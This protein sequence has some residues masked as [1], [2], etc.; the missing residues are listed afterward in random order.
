MFREFLENEVKTQIMTFYL[1]SWPFTMFFSTS[2]AWTR[3]NLT[4][5]YDSIYNELLFLFF[6]IE[7]IDACNKSTSIWIEYIYRMRLWW[8]FEQKTNT[9]WSL[10]KMTKILFSEISLCLA[11]MWRIRIFASKFICLLSELASAVHNLQNVILKLEIIC[12]LFTWIL[13]I[14]SSTL[15]DFVQYDSWWTSNAFPKK[16][17]SEWCNLTWV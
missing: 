8:L 2:M 9:K 11:R 14:L 13:T 5:H 12:L 6:R 16:K 1:F 3:Q 4:Q 7:C 17:F 10:A 15:S